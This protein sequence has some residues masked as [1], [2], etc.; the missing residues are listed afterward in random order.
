MQLHG[1][2]DASE[3]AYAG[4]VYLRMHDSEGHVLVALVMSKTKVAPIKRITIP[5]LELCGAHLLAQML[6]HVEL[7]ELMEYIDKQRTERTISD[8]FSIQGTE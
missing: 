2:S 4:V 8:F 3:R 7:R 1:F 6:H 5:R